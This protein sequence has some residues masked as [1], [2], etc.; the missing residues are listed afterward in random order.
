ML[1]F[2]NS[3][4]MGNHWQKPPP[5]FFKVNTNGAYYP[6]SGSS[7]FGGL[8]RDDSGSFVRGFF[9][10]LSTCNALYA[11]M[12]GLLQGIKIAHEMA[13][14]QVVFE[15]DSLVV[16]EMINKG[17]TNLFFIKPLLKE[18]IHLLKLPSW[19]TMVVVVS[20]EANTCAD[21]LAFWGLQASFYIQYVD[22]V[23]RLLGILVSR[24][25]GGND[26]HNLVS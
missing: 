20:R 14:S 8:T 6:F 17:F 1:V 16:F 26:P 9:C 24:E 15:V 12:C 21:M 3:S 4:D 23:C 13:L 2:S 19:K 11:E 25:S 22:N 10:K 5:G 18:V 7:S